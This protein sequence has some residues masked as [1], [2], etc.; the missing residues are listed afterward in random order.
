M[1]TQLNQVTNHFSDNQLLSKLT[2]A[3]SKI[4]FRAINKETGSIQSLDGTFNQLYSKLVNLN[5]DGYCI[6]A[7]I[8]ETDSLGVKAENITAIKALFI[9]LDDSTADNKLMIEKLPITP[10]IVIET[11]ANKY[12]VYWILNKPDSRIGLFTHVTGNFTRISLSNT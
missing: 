10:S 11:S 1:N 12:H 4:P 3:T 7:T 2:K 6:F 8:N 9:D 5:N